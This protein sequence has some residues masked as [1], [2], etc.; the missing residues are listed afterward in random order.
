MMQGIISYIKKVLIC[1]KFNIIYIYIYNIIKLIIFDS[2]IFDS[3]I[4]EL[5][6][7]YNYKQY[8]YMEP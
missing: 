1:N 3:I 5:V 2:I 4:F 7:Y 8:N 6:V